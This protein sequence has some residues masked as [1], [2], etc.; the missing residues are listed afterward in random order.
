METQKNKVATVRKEGVSDSGKPS[1]AINEAKGMDAVGGGGLSSN[2]EILLSKISIKDLEPFKFICDDGSI[3]YRTTVFLCT[4][5]EY[6][7]GFSIHGEFISSL[8]EPLQA[9]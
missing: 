2:A 6:R 9:V 3:R 7:W 8:N 5:G 1:E 4:D